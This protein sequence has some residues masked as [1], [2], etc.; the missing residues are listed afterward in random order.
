MFFALASWLLVVGGVAA[1]IVIL[2]VAAILWGR[3]LPEAFSAESERVV[4]SPISEVWRRASDEAAY[5]LTGRYCR[6]VERLPDVS[7]L[8]AFREDLDRSAVTVQTAESVPPRRLV[9]TGEDSV[10]PMKLRTEI[11][12]EAEG[13]STRVRAKHSI[14]V[15]RGTWHVPIFRAILKVS[16]GA[17]RSLDQYLRSL[18]SEPRSTGRAES[19]SRRDT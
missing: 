3:S 13:S 6:G 17:R 16:G 1:A 11:T 15:R 18:D 9:R 7:G 19:T 10:V 12:L 2:L 14:Q 4:H 8:P 5:P